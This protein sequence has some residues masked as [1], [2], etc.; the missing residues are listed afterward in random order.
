M[1]AI[2]KILKSGRAAL[3]LFLASVAF[4]NAPAQGGSAYSVEALTDGFRRTVF[5]SEFGGF[6][7]GYVRKFSGPVSFYIRPVTGADRA[8]VREVR[9]FVRQVDRSVRNF[10]ARFV[11]NEQSADFVVHITPRRLYARTVRQDVYGRNSAPVRGLC[12]VRARYGRSGISRSDAVIVSDEGNKLFQ[13][14]M[15]EEILQGLGPL[16]DDS[17]LKLSVFND[18]SNFSTFRR[19]DRLLLNILY[20][21]RIKNGQNWRRTRRILPTVIEDTKRRIGR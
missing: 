13:R 4:N 11:S 1:R 6:G 17:S 10:S 9:R 20:D 15:V 12:M 8:K 5:A 19:F 2:P 7:S 16:N 14:C 18:T 21:P 3:A